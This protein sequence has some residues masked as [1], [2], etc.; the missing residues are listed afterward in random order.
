MFSFGFLR[1]DEHKTIIKSAL[2]LPSLLGLIF[3]GW[4]LHALKVI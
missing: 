3:I 1:A 2:N 4:V